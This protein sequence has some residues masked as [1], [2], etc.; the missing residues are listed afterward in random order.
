M[1]DDNISSNS[2][3]RELRSRI[4]AL[5]QALHVAISLCV[6]ERLGGREAARQLGLDKT[7][8]WK[9]FQFARPASANRESLSDLP[10]T[11]PLRRGRTRHDN[12]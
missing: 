1:S 11:R 5:R 10:R 7:L 6:K 2:N 3:A 12:Q 8:G 9:A 4:T